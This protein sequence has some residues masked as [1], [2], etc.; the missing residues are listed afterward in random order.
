MTYRYGWGNTR[1]SVNLRLESLDPRDLP[2]ATSFVLGLLETPTQR[3]EASTSLDPVSSAGS[4]DVAAE[5]PKD[6]GPAA[7]G[8]IPE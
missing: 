5:G 7:N 6:K 2:S 1:R 8:G 3:G 4:T